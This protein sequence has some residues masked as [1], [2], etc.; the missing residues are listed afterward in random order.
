MGCVLFATPRVCSLIVS[1]RFEQDFKQVVDQMA[2]VMATNHARADNDY[3]ADI[4]SWSFEKE[5]SDAVH[6]QL[7]N[8]IE[9]LRSMFCLFVIQVRYRAEEFIHAVADFA[10]VY[11]AR[12]QDDYYCLASAYSR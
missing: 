4:I 6:T 11:Y 7:L 12:V 9:L 8:K 1:T 10:D 3:N 5:F 2:I